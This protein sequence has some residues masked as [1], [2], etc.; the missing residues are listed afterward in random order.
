M[1]D[2]NTLSGLSDDDLRLRLKGLSNEEKRRMIKILI[3]EINEKT[4]NGA[5]DDDL[6]SISE[7]LSKKQ[8]ERMIEILMQGKNE[9][10]ENNVGKSEIPQELKDFREAWKK[11]WN[12]L[13]AATIEKIVNAAEKIN[14]KV[15]TDKEDGSRL[16]KFSLN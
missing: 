8:K 14:V 1:E 2:Y 11:K 5:N 9:E 4:E 6:K 10:T 13:P 16:I 3:Q 15:E 12:T 7:G